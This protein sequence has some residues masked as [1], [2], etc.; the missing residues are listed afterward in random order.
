MW[1]LLCIVIGVVVA[2]A[3]SQ[4]SGKRGEGL[5]LDAMLGIT[6][7]YAGG[8]VFNRLSQ[9]DGESLT[10]Q[11]VLASVVGAAAVLGFSWAIDGRGRAVAGDSAKQTTKR[12]RRRR[13]GER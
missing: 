12:V 9:T 10:I 6:G 2:V 11:S 13:R 5:G 1:L 7:A 3:A 4:V 8:F